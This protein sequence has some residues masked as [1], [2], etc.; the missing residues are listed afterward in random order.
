MEEIEII[1][2]ELKNGVVRKKYMQLDEW[3]H[4]HK[5][6][7]KKGFQYIAYKKGFSQFKITNEKK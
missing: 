4:F 3:I 5:N 6:K 2:I 7:R 1:A